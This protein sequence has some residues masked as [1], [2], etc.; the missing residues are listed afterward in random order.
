MQIPRVAHAYKHPLEAGAM[1]RRQEL[2]CVLWSRHSAEAWL[3]RP[4]TKS[5]QSRLLK[6]CVLSQGH[7]FP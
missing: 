2:S 4:R 3:N 6:I 1:K 7:H 5:V